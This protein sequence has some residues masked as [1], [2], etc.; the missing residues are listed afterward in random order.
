MLSG[1]LLV[2]FWG[3]VAILGGLSAAA[4]LVGL[5]RGR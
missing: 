2:V 5:G 1:A 3:L 4:F